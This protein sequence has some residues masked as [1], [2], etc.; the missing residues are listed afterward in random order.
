MCGV[1]VRV[2]DQRMSLVEAGWLKIRQG[3]PKRSIIY[4]YIVHGCLFIF[5]FCGSVKKSKKKCKLECSSVIVFSSS[6]HQ[7]RSENYYK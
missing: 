5:I 6:L 2:K 7:N 3:H 1:A 4:I